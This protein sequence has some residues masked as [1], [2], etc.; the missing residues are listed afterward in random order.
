MGLQCSIQLDAAGPVRGLSSPQLFRKS[1]T[2]ADLRSAYVETNEAAA[3]IFI[4]TFPVTRL[5][6]TYMQ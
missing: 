2:K 6:T 1:T 4:K 3:E 5:L